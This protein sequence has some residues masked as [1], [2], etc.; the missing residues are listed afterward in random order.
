MTSIADL[1]EMRP[2]ILVFG[3]GGAGG[4]AINNMIA[5]GL[6]GVDFVVA[7]R[8]ALRCEKTARN[9][10]S[11]VALACAFILIKSVHTT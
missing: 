6:Q 8:I 11:F 9:Y 5:A 1:R 3:V 7:K 2:R 4:N 10:G